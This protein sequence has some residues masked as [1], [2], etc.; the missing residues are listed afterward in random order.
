MNGNK[1]EAVSTQATSPLERFIGAA[2]GPLGIG[3]SIAVVVVLGIVD[4]LTGPR[5]S[6]APFYLMPVVLATWTGGRVWGLGIAGMAAVATRVAD[7]PG[8][9]SVFVHSWNAIEWFVV[10]VAVAWLVDALRATVRHQ[11]SR[12]A[13]ET[14]VVDV[15]RAQ[16]DMKNTLLHAVSHDLK[17]P[18]AGVLG[19]MQTI[20]RAERLHLTDTEM[21]D[22][23]GVI[24]Q[25]GSKAARLVDDLLDL[26]RLDRGQLELQ[27]EPTDV[28]S[29]AERLAGELPTLAGHP[30]RVDGPRLLVDVDATLAERIVENL[31][32]NA[33]RHTP[34]GTPIHIEVVGR[35][36]GVV[37][38]VED[39]GPGVPDDLKASIFEPFEQGE[40]ARGGVGIGL[41]LVGRF[42]ELHGGSAHVEDRD[43][44]GA[45]FVV[46][47]PG[48]VAT[49][50]V[51]G[52]MPVDLQ[53]V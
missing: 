2:P 41:S 23:Y 8:N 18:L 20:R 37:V 12:L 22:L 4:H 35:P 19:A 15:L 5:V 53:A 6:L 24:E 32:N 34:P 48:D 7:P 36:N 52:T 46:T 51:T 9:A 29:L 45:R 27:R 30:V 42:A 50:P 14:E 44:G 47:L 31:M 16:N 40:N 1:A 39:E 10:L 28:E 43:G 33:A 38:V 17:G 25:A 13:H 21:N 11:R 26:D 49:L 3:L